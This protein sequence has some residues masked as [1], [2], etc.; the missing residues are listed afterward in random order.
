MSLKIK[1]CSYCL[2]LSLIIVIISYKHGY[3]YTQMGMGRASSFPGIGKCRDLTWTTQVPGRKTVPSREF[4]A[5]EVPALKPLAWP[6]EYGAQYTEYTTNYIQVSIHFEWWDWMVTGHFSGIPRVMP[7]ILYLRVKRK[8][9]AR[10]VH[11]ITGEQKLC[12]K[13]RKKTRLCLLFRNAFERDGR[14]RV[15]ADLLALRIQLTLWG[16]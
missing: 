8:K 16:K 5:L 12:L 11:E 6:S 3:R 10:R 15:L 9:N 13:I 7:C 2:V 1:Y 14:R 4:L